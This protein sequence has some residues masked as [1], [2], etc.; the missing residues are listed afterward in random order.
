VPSAIGRALADLDRL[1]LRGSAD[2][3]GDDGDESAS[4]AVA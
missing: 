4:E 3:M 1:D 2:G